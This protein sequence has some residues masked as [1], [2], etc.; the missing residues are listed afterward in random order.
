MLSTRIQRREAHVDLWIL[1][2][3]CL[4]GILLLIVIAVILYKVRI[5]SALVLFKS[6]YG[7]TIIVRMV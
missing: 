6:K 2:A 4:V 3:A 1:I 5:N 7:N